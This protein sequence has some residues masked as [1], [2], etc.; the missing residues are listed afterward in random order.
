MPTLR[1][2]K[3][4]RPAD[5][6]LYETITF[7]HDSFGYVYLVANQLKEQVF[8]GNNYLPVRMDVTQSQQ[9]STPVINA[10]LKFSRLAMDFKQKLKLWSA[11]SRIN[12][13]SATYKRFVSTDRDTPLRPYTLYV[14]NVAMDASDVTCT[15]SMKNPLKANVSELYDIQQFPGLRNV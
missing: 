9:S 14:S 4:K 11:G 2:F 15:L 6:I 5:K 8:D 10:T 7:Y 3:S 1:E 12:P 13:I